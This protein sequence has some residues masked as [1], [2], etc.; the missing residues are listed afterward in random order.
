MILTA[1]KL[2]SIKESKQITEIHRGEDEEEKIIKRM[3]ST[4][5]IKA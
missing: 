2:G 5:N 4:I 3:Y 1:K